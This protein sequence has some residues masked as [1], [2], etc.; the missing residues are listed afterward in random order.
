MKT[1]TLKNLFII[2]ISGVVYGKSLIA[3]EIPT[4]GLS[5]DAQVLVHQSFVEYKNSRGEK[6]L[7]LLFPGG[8]D[9]FDPEDARGNQQKHQ[10]FYTIDANFSGIQNP[11]LQGDL[12]DENLWKEIEDQTIDIT[13]IEIPGDIFLDYSGSM[14]ISQRQKQ[15]EFILKKVNAKSKIGGQLF[16]DLRYSRFAPTTWG[17]SLDYQECME[18][19]QTA[20]HYDP[21]FFVGFSYGFHASESASYWYSLLGGSQEEIDYVLKNRSD[22]PRF[23]QLMHKISQQL[24][25]LNT[26]EAYQLQAPYIIF[27]DIDTRFKIFE[28]YDALFK[29]YGFQRSRPIIELKGRMD[30][31]FEFEYPF[32]QIDGRI[33]YE[34]MC[35][36]DTIA[37]YEKVQ[38]L[39][40]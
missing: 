39:S 6:P 23:H 20:M 9:S 37:Q 28:Q 16:V 8:R 15:D 11:H 35:F 3:M 31:G 25:N 32:Q 13:H 18:F 7:K 26:E 22:V 10:G 29:Q 21:D 12:F 14:P 5:T 30:A 19:V 4:P 2:L 40:L 27:F 34:G 33:I 17:C 1:L 24:E 38:H 36:L